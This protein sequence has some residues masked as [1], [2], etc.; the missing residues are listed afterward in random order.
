M[1]KDVREKRQ[2]ILR[3]DELLK[4]FDSINHAMKRHALLKTAVEEKKQ[5]SLIE[6]HAEIKMLETQHEEHAALKL[7]LISLQD[8]LEN[9]DS[10]AERREI[11]KLSRYP[12]FSLVD[13]SKQTRLEIDLLV[14]IQNQSLQTIV[15]KIRQTRQQCENLELQYDS[16]AR[17]Y[18]AQEEKCRLLMNKIQSAPLLQKVAVTQNE[19]N[20]CV[21]PPET[22]RI[23]EAQTGHPTLRLN[24]ETTSFL[25]CIEENLGSNAKSIW[26]ALLEH[27]LR[28]HNENIVEKCVKKGSQKYTLYL[29][30]PLRIWLR[31]TN[32][33]GE[34]DPKGGIILMLGKKQKSAVS[35]AVNFKKNGIMAFENGGA[36]LYTKL[37]AWA[38]SIISKIPFIK[39]TEYATANITEFKKQ[40]NSSFSLKAR[41]WGASSERTK[42]FAE[43]K[44]NWGKNG[45]VLKR[46]GT[47]QKLDD[48]L[49][50]V[51]QAHLHS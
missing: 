6:L 37:P 4:T 26:Q 23:R 41:L 20:S 35:L 36:Q 16:D 15:Q 47:Q 14:Q 5:K 46:N 13:F 49:K 31:S 51:I 43:L 21:T 45:Q 10:E 27:F 12:C 7:L 18:V 8:A 48:Y 24:N 2:M 22:R 39:I 40:T 34:E 30:Q 19:Q 11:K 3:K 25:R 28:V 44:E 32:N 33:H 42:S 9:K 17:R 1:Q 50:S 29:K 38:I